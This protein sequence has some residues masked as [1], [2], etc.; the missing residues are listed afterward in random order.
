MEDYWFI[1]FI[2]NKFKICFLYFAEPVLVKSDKKDSSIS[3]TMGKYTY[4][5]C[6]ICAVVHTYM[7]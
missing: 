5:I 2:K 4:I 3:T 7:S 6:I 1:D